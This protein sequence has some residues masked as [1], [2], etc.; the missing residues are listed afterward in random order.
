MVHL[1]FLPPLAYN[2]AHSLPIIE[3]IPVVGIADGFVRGSPARRIK[4]MS[5]VVW[6][7]LRRLPKPALLGLLVLLLTAMARA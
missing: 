2:S 3:G 5:F 1:H 6:K 4:S 7:I